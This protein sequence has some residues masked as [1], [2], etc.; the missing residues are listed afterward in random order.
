M[1][2]LAIL[3]MGFSLMAIHG[4]RCTEDGCNIVDPVGGDASNCP[5]GWIS[6]D[7]QCY[8]VSPNTL[9]WFQAQEV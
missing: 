7:S 8:H 1:L 9:N 3:F 4:L 2:K 5:D 6:A